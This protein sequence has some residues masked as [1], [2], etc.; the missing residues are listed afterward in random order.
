MKSAE[1]ESPLGLPV[2]VIWYE[3]ADAA[4]TTNEA[5]TTPLLIEQVSEAT[6]APPDN[7]HAES[8]DEKPEPDT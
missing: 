6:T 5:V 1:P 2:M 8:L 7:E 3:P 4:A